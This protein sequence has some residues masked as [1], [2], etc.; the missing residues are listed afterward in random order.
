MKIFKA[1]RQA[2]RPLGTGQIAELVGMTR[3]TV[4]RHLT[5]MPDAEIVTWRGEQ[6][7][8]PHATWR[9]N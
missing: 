7:K 1:M 3:P 4:L 2:Q 5:R 6:P 8:D 9:L